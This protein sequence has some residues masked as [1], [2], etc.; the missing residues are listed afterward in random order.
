MVMGGD[1]QIGRWHLCQ[2]A[3]KSKLKPRSPIAGTDV[4]IFKIFSPKKLAFFTQNKAELCKNL[5]IT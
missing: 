1:R 5:I 2:K 3:Q 4:V